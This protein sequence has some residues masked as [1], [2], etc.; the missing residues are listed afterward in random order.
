MKWTW[1]L[2]SFLVGFA[3]PFLFLVMLVEWFVYYPQVHYEW[4]DGDR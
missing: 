3:L 4:M 2:R 1:V